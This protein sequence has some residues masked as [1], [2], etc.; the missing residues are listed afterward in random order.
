MAYRTIKTW[1]GAVPT[2]GQ[3]PAVLVPFNVNPV[4]G[5]KMK[6]TFNSVDRVYSFHDNDGASTRFTSSPT[7]ACQIG[8]TPKDTIKNL[9]CTIHSNPVDTRVGTDNTITPQASGTN[10]IVYGNNKITTGPSI[11]FVTSTGSSFLGSN[12]TH[13]VGADVSNAYG[14]SPGYSNVYSAISFNTGTSHQILVIDNPN[15][16]GYNAGPPKSN[17]KVVTV[18]LA[19]HV[20]HEI[21]TLGCSTN[22]ILYG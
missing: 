9:I 16:D 20:I 5:Q 19:P 2:A 3:F 11:A 13:Q 14:M 22:C 7:S 4:D 6:I 17:L 15:D 8:A 1:T 18:N 21:T 12:S 10:L